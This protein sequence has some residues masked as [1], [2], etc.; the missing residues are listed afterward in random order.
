MQSK[1]KDD[2]KA[3]TNNLGE[4]P[5]DNT[6]A[7]KSP[8]LDDTNTDKNDP[9][10]IKK[11]PPDSNSSNFNTNNQKDETEEMFSGEDSDGGKPGGERSKT[12]DEPTAPRPRIVAIRMM[13]WK[14]RAIKISPI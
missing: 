5:P 3:A 7:S 11:K 8:H 1:N 2:D 4:K 10:E 14:C 13:F 9:T 12:A 6:E